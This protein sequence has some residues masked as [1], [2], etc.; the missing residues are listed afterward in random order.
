MLAEAQALGFRVVLDHRVVERYDHQVDAF[1]WA[2]CGPRHVVALAYENYRLYVRRGPTFLSIRTYTDGG[3]EHDFTSYHNQLLP[4]RLL[5]DLRALRRESG[6]A[7]PSGYAAGLQRSFYLEELGEF[8][9]Q[10]QDFFDDRNGTNTAM[11]TGRPSFTLD[12]D[13]VLNEFQACIKE[14][15]ERRRQHEQYYEERYL[16]GAGW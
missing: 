12:L 14:A 15:E 1:D 10:F 6:G 2:D 13:E 11:S 7:S 16:P 8:S 5:A 4:E 3:D 9:C